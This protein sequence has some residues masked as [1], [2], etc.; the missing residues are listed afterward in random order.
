[1]ATPT[2]C[3]SDDLGRYLDNARHDE[4]LPI[5]NFNSRLRTL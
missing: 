4:T 5:I 2:N 1:M 3:S